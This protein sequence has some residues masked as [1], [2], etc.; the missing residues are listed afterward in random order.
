MTKKKI[1]SKAKKSTMKPKAKSVSEYEI[2]NIDEMIEDMKK[3]ALEKTEEKKETESIVAAHED[4]KDEKIVDYLNESKDNV[5]ISTEENVIFTNKEEGESFT[6][7]LVKCEFDEEGN[8]VN[9]DEINTMEKNETKEETEEESA[10]EENENEV[11][12]ENK[13]KETENLEKEKEIEN[14]EDLSFVDEIK[15]QDITEEE[16]KEEPKKENK[17]KRKTYQ[18]MFGHS[19][20]GYGYS[21]EY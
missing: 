17:A 10:K 21:N 19:W 3:L 18:E 13:N 5:V 16:K 1:M 8:L 9:E 11:I 15:E 14:A 4:V 2:K 12:E 6:G 20:M 7:P